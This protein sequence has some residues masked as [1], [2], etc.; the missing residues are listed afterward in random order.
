VIVFAK[1]LFDC[2]PSAEKIQNK[3]NGYPSAFDDGF[4]DKD[5]RIHDDPL[6]PIH[7]IPPHAAHI[8]VVIGLV[9]NPVYLCIPSQPD[10][11]RRIFGR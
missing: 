11:F 5:F 9:G 4:P 3:L 7:R 1:D 10:F 6:M 8:V 2:P